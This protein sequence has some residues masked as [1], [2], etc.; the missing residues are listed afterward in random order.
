[1]QLTELIAIR[2]SRE[3]DA[4]AAF[5]TLVNVGRVPGQKDGAAKEGEE[6][7]VTG[8]QLAAVLA[9]FELKMSVKDIIKDADSDNNG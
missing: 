2:L 9:E 8:A 7:A 5:S 3:E 4:L 6:A 1:M